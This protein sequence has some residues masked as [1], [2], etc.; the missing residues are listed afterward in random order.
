MTTDGPSLPTPTVIR[1]RL[2]F[3]L[4]LGAL[5]AAMLW[6]SYWLIQR[7]A[8]D[9][10]A[11]FTPA[12]ELAAVADDLRQATAAQRLTRR[13]LS[14]RHLNPQDATL[15]RETLAEVRDTLIAAGY[16]VELRALPGTGGRC[17]RLDLTS[18]GWTLQDDWPILA[19]ACPSTLA[20]PYPDEP[21]LA[22][23]RQQIQKLGGTGPILL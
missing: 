10:D 23:L 18:L 6:S 20:V 22:E 14:L 2:L 15:W 1:R 19:K 12:A 11:P 13:Y 3:A 17:H 4:S 7:I 16:A 21:S 8:D 5:F 9:P